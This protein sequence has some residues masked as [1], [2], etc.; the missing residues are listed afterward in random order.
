MLKAS[1]FKNKEVINLSNSEKLGFV[2]DFEICTS[3]GEISA[4]LVPDRS[5]S[6][7]SIKSNFCRIPWSKISG[8]GD[9]II[10]V[11]IDADV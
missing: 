6:F 2:C 5:K 11:N 1:E 7:F 8:I 4:I 9:D 10:L 3:S